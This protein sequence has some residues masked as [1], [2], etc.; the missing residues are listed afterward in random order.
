MVEVWVQV[1]ARHFLDCK[2]GWSVGCAVR[3][4]THFFSSWRVGNYNTCRLVNFQGAVLVSAFWN[5]YLSPQK[6]M[7]PLHFL[8]CKRKEPSFFHPSHSFSGARLST[9]VLYWKRDFSTLPHASFSFFL[10]QVGFFF[11]LWRTGQSPCWRSLY[12]KRLIC[13]SWTSAC[14]TSCDWSWQK[15]RWFVCVSTFNLSV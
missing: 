2:M 6:T 5:S 8:V 7:T 14:E 9:G 1:R 12:G 15:P 3:P 10:M 4:P 13:W 11:V